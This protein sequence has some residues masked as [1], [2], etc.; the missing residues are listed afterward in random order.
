MSDWRDNAR[1][2]FDASMHET[3]GHYNVV[4]GHKAGQYMGDR[5]ILFRLGS[6]NLPPPN[7]SSKLDIPVDA[8]GNRLDRGE[9]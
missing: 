3:S 9:G 7:R 5:T 4:L 6:S 1:C 8:D 2:G